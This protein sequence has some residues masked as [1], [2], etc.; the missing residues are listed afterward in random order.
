[1]PAGSPTAPPVPLVTIP[2]PMSD[3]RRRQKEQRAARREEERK[4][5]SRRELFRRLGFA[6]AMGALVAASF[7]VVSLFGEDADSLPG[8]YEGYRSQP[9]AC[10]AEQPPPEVVRTYSEYQQQEDVG[11]D[12][13]VT[14]TLVTSCGD[15]VIE[16]ATDMSPETVQSFVFLAREDFYDGMVFYRILKDFRADTGD[17]EAVGTGGPGYRLPDE[18]PPADFEF[19]R[20]VVAMDNRGRNTSGSRFFVVLGEDAAILNPSFNILGRIVD[21]DETLQRLE[22]IP[23]ATRP[24]SREVSLP[25]ETV[26]IEDVE[27][28]VG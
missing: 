11:P 5:E 1:M 18:Y 25:L 8:S 27:I 15:L 19:E 3:R 23:T 20:G 13:T 9:T 12:S 28:E 10:G 14:A 4:A 16:L 22:E 21:G 26:Y 17:P 24:G 6:L 2:G 7:I